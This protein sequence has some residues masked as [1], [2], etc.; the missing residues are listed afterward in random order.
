MDKETI[1][2]IIKGRMLEFL[3]DK[4]WEEL[5]TFHKIEVDLTPDAWAEVRMFVGGDL[6]RISADYFHPEEEYGTVTAEATDIEVYYGEGDLLFKER[7]PEG[8][9]V[10]L[11]V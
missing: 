2:G 1:Y 11:N 10:F 7:H 5:D 3:E 4:E 9:K 6:T 8:L